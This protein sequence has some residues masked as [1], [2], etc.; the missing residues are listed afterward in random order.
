MLDIYDCIDKE[1]MI[2]LD[3]ELPVV[4]TSTAKDE[5]VAENKTARVSPDTL[6]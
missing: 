1:E 3:K 4:R 2:D 5:K 6:P